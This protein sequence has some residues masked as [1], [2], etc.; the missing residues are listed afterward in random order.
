MSKIPDSWTSTTIAS[1]TKS[2]TSIDPTM[3]PKRI[4]K[5][6]D[7]GS[8]DNKT[9]T[10]TNQKMFPGIGAPSRARRVIKQ[11]DTLFST[12]RTYLKN[13]AIVP[14]ELDGE[15]T[16]TG[17]SVLRPNGAIDPRYLFKWT[18]TDEFVSALSSAQ[19]GTMYPAV[20]DRD[21][22]DATIRL[23]P[24]TEQRRIVSKV[25]S[26]CAKSGRARN[27]LD[28]LP[29]LVEKYKQ[30]VLAVAF[31]GDLTR[32]W[33][34]AHRRNAEWKRTTIGDAL[35]DIRYGTAKKC[36]YHDGGTPVLRIPNVQLG[37]ITVEDLKFADFD[38]R[39]VAKLRLN[40]GDILIIRSNGSLDL[41]GRSAVVNQAALGMLFAG[42]LIRLRLDQKLAD[43]TFIH[44]YFMASETRIKLET[45]AKS[46]S[47]VNNINS[48]QLQALPLLLP[49][50]AEQN[51]IVRRV[52]RAFAWIDRLAA[53]ATNAR[54]LVDHLDRAVLA[55]AFRGELV[56][57]DPSD[58]PANLLLERIRAERPSPRSSTGA[59]GRSK[60]TA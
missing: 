40:L 43:P 42:Y 11:G 27:H 23:P 28:H 6:V 31:R 48:S 37:Q 52:E 32:E 57:Q 2:I 25:E 14:S 21:V 12:V 4:F 56:P 47:G 9:Q 41:V 26:L 13:I 18:C 44:L 16:S 7:I 45:L 15:L 49:E 58:E 5:Y 19:D 3:T 36:S 55:K 39:E 30:A 10:I 34:A 50:V 8:I 35:I 33:R 60:R 46:T 59:R 53:E 54:R 20:S 24:L 51:E 17:I 1:V 38:G 22:A 29:R